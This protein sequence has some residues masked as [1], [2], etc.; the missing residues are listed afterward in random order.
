MHHHRT[1]DSVIVQ[2]HFWYTR[3]VKDTEQTARREIV[4]RHYI[5]GQEVTAEAF[6]ERLAAEV[7]GTWERGL[8]ATLP[9]VKRMSKRID[10]RKGRT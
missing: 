6:A 3:K 9:E 8:G 4:L 10:C 2:P 5:A 1:T 7:L